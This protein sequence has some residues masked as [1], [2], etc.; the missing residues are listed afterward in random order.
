MRT[1][2][3]RFPWLQLCTYCTKRCMRPS[4]WLHL[5]VRE[6]LCPF[7]ARFRSCV[8]GTG[9]PGFHVFC[10]TT[11]TWIR[12]GT[13]STAPSCGD[14]GTVTICMPC[15]ATGLSQHVSRG[16]PARCCTQLVLASW[17]AQ[18]CPAWRWRIA[19]VDLCRERH[20]SNVQD[21]MF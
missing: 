2:R 4:A 17:A 20:S 15:G 12:S 7:R 10:T 14:T 19:V 1:P 8:S 18:A 13:Q 21:H 11:G 5:T 16:S 3:T 6:Q 9:T